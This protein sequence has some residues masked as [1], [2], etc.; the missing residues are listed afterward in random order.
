MA[1]IT[2]RNKLT[3]SYPVL[4]AIH[5]L[6][7]MYHILFSQ[8]LPDTASFLHTHRKVL[9]MLRSPAIS[10]TTPVSIR[11]ECYKASHEYSRAEIKPLGFCNDAHHKCNDPAPLS[12]FF[13]IFTRRLVP[14]LSAPRLMNFSAS[15]N[16]LIPPAAFTFTPSPT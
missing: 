12:V 16:E 11:C 1:A 8:S 7:Y 13:M 9:R 4:T 3:R 10:P 2:D 5:F 15:S 14:S 6:P